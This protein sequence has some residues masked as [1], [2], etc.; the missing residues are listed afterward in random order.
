M[1]SI[2]FYL[3]QNGVYICSHSFES[4]ANT[5]YD[6]DDMW[7]EKEL[8]EENLSLIRVFD[9]EYNFYS[10]IPYEL[11]LSRKNEMMTELWIRFSLLNSTSGNNFEYIVYS[12]ENNSVKRV[13]AMTED[14]L[15]IDFIVLNS[16]DNSIIGVSNNESL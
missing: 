6:S 13:T 1:I 5:I 14:N 2:Y 9:D 10:A 15:K 11:V 7:V 3:N 8:F 4:F 16:F 12:M